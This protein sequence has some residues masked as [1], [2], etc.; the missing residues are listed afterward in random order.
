MRYTLLK[1]VELILSSM[2]SDEVN[3]IGDST[4]SRQVVDVIETVYNDI[5]STIDFPDNWDLFELETDADTDRPTEMFLPASV[6][7][8]EYIQ[9]DWSEGGERNYKDVCFMPRK[10]FFDRMNSLDETQPN[11]YSK[12][13]TVGTGTFNIR[14]YN[15]R[16]P[17]YYTTTDDNRLLF[18]NYKADVNQTLVGNRTKCYGMIIP[19]FQRDDNFIPPLEPRQ[20]TLL[21][22]EAKSQAFAEVKQMTNAKAERNARRG[23][24]LAHRKEPM[25][26]GESAYSEAP[27]FG[28]TGR[29]L[30]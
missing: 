2:D 24:N 15:D 7:K 27:N 23:W 18:D 6:S 14:G 12:T 25:I 20:F 3:S 21:F 28:R 4:E 5:V 29:R 10:L 9:Y 11:V 19:V 1:M 26:P 8:L 13:Y 30:F 16:F 22:N 17:T